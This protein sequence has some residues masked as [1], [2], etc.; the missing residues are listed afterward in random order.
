MQI[1]SKE[2]FTKIKFSNEDIDQEK[3]CHCFASAFLMPKDA[4]ES[5]FGSFRVKISFCELEAFKQEYKVS[6]AA[7]LYRLKD[8]NII[9]D[10]LYK[11]LSIYISKNI[12]KNDPNP[13]I[14]EISCGFKRIVHKLKANGIITLNKACELL[15]VSADEYNRE[16][17]SY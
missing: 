12:G 4:I 16:D 3:M 11:K 15:G 5:E 10:H 13:I 8:L 2:K 17:Y 1:L 6:Y 14:P 9:N 7:I